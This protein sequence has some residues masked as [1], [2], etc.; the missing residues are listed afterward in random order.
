MRRPMRCQVKVDV[1][2]VSMS[3]QA[4]DRG[5][6][7]VDAL[8]TAAKPAPTKSRQVRHQGF[9]G[10]GHAEAADLEAVLKASE[11]LIFLRKERVE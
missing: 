8:K 1:Q 4:I 2:W 9:T 10:V 5:W 7:I 6:A 3:K 11:F